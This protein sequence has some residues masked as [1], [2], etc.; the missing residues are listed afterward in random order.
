MGKLSITEAR[1]MC[2][3]ESCLD[4]ESCIFDENIFNNDKME[5]TKQ[6]T[7]VMRYY[8]NSCPFLKKFKIS[9]SSTE[10]ANWYCTHKDLLSQLNTDEK[11]IDISIPES[12]MVSTPAFCPINKGGSAH[13]SSEPTLHNSTKTWHDLN[14]QMDFAAIK[15]GEVYHIPP[16]NGHKRKD[17]LITY[18]TEYSATYRVISE[19][20]ATYTTN[21]L[22]PN[23]LEGK[24]VVPHYLREFKNVKK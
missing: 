14:G 3:K 17:I 11:L 8:C 7:K 21:T 5:E 13:A 19:D 16:H 15:V 10:Y 2:G 4:C 12:R 23:T 18:K 22:F 20:E 6:P 24:L 9:S 1:G